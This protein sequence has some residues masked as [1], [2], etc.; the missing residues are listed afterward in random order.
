[1]S[2]PLRVAILNLM[3]DCP[4]VPCERETSRTG[5]NDDNVAS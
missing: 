2:A 4:Y 5:L 1:M 3:F